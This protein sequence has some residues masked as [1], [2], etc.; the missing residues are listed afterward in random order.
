MA[1]VRIPIVNEELCK[2]VA[3]SDYETLTQTPAMQFFSALVGEQAIASALEGVRQTNLVDE[4]QAMVEDGNNYLAE[5]ILENMEM[6]RCKHFASGA[7]L[8]YK[9][10]RAAIVAEALEQMEEK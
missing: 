10:M 2:R 4:M 5:L 3:Q 1:N 8:V 9:L 6:L 7:L